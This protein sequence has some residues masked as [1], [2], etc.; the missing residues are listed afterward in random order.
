MRPKK[1]LSGTVEEQLAQTDRMLRHMSLRTHKTIVGLVPPI[2]L[3]FYAQGP[4]V[5]GVVGRFIF[6]VSGV[7]DRITI[8]FD[9]I[10]DKE[11]V[12]R[13][14]FSG[15]DST[16]SKDILVKGKVKTVK[17]DTGIIVGDMVTVYVY[18]AIGKIPA[19]VSGIWIGA[20]LMPLKSE[21]GSEQVMI[22]ELEKV[23]EETSNA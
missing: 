8:A 6:A 23:G 18:E 15:G 13:F 22:E 1:F 12:V 2:P 17:A 7:I 9:K 4:D 21:L 5:D 20:R 10:A 16:Y 11:V 14:E 3:S 19:A